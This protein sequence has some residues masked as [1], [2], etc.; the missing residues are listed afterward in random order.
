[1]SPLR[2]I[3]LGYVIRGPLGG[4]TWH[5]LQYVLGLT[6]LGHDVY[7]FEDSDDYQSCYDPSRMTM[8][9]DPAY[10]LAYAAD[11]FSRVGLGDRWAF[12]DAHTRRW[13]GPCAASALDI[14]ASADIV[15]NVSG[16]NPLRSWLMQAPSR[17]LIDTD[18]AFTQV[19]HLTDADACRVATAHTAFFSFG[20]C[21][22]QRSTIPD[23]GLP[24]KATRQPVVLDMW[25]VTPGPE[26]GH[27]TTVMVWESYEPREYE[28]RRYGLKSESLLSYLDLP[29][30]TTASFEL[31]IG[32]SSEV[33]DTLTQCGWAV[34]NPLVVARDPWEYQAYIRKS[35]AE[36]SVAKHGYV[37][38][39]SGWFSERS[40]AYLAS[41][42]PVVAQDTGFSDH[43]PTGEG[44]LSFRTPDD[45]LAAIE[46]VNDDYERHCNAAR[47]LAE[48]HFDARLVLS[49]L[50]EQALA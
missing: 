48:R 18:P 39:R 2:I 34:C 23:D 13:L 28:G 1:M 12:Y 15:L 31:A 43:L 8:G 3:V 17:V 46:S 24:W 26:Q 45:A 36:F 7:F 49:R 10:G 38:S 41:G 25:P 11:A 22:G 16:V 47:L 29:A 35:R 20:E 50:V 9:V 42:R 30:S 5:H 19:R 21:I 14:C 44:L 32:A 27:F 6:Q 4:M 37:A 33:K 40:T